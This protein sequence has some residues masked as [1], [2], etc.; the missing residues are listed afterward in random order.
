MLSDVSAFALE[1]LADVRFAAPAAVGIG[2]VEEVDAQLPGHV[3]QRESLFLGL[4]L[5][6]EGGRAAHAAEVATAQAHGGDFEARPSQAFVM[7]S[8][9]LYKLSN[10]ASSELYYPNYIAWGGKG[11]QHGRCAAKRRFNP[12]R[13]KPGRDHR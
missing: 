13:R 4:A 7:H 6:E 10:F 5:A 12:K 1:P 2:G 8:C 11:K 9:A 3:H